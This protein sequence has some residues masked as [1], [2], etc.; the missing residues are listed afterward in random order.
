MTARPEF[1][2][3]WA[4][5][6]LSAYELACISSV[7]QRGHAL[8]LYSYDKITNV[9][10]RVV[11]ADA[12]AI[13]D[14]RFVHGFLIKGKPSLSHFSDLFR[15]RLFEQTQAIWIDSDMLMLKPLELAIPPVFLAR[16]DASRLCGA[17][18]R[19]QSDHPLLP[20]L[21]QSTEEV[22]DRELVWGETGPRLLT[23]VFGVKELAEAAYGAE[24]F[25]P[26]H[27]TELWKAFLPEHREECE[28]MCADACT[29]HLWNSVVGHLA[30]WKKFMPPV[31]SYLESRFRSDGTV[32]FFADAYPVAI[33]RQMVE[34]W[35]LRMNGGDLALGQLA[36]QV[37]PGLK[38]TAER[39]G[40]NLRLSLRRVPARPS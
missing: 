38:R 19:I 40:A 2:S 1:A 28:A 25:Y 9:P 24:L 26:L 39:R 12:R 37:I 33:M 11:E 36:R 22:A 16:E 14:E 7:V 8:T 6:S 29:V 35:R 30:V 5:G 10:D 21:V 3:F 34:N 13:V 17:I 23:K 27:Y 15:Y 31:G 4:G 20:S 18:M 32:H